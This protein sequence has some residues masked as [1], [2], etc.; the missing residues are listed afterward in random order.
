MILVKVTYRGST[1]KREYSYIYKG[2]GAIN[3]GDVVVVPLGKNREKH[4][5]VTDVFKIR[6]LIRTGE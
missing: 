1:S 5:I 6:E 2:I 3:I 4:A